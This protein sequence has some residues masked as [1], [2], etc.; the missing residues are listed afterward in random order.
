MNPKKE[1]EQIG[2]CIFSNAIKGLK[3]GKFFVPFVG[4]GDEKKCL[5]VEI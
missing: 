2:Q 1:I 5:L 3:N 4:Y